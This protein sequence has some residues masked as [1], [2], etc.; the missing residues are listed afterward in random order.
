MLIPLSQQ[1]EAI[2]MDNIKAIKDYAK[3]LG[4]TNIS[5]TEFDSFVVPSDGY[6][7]MVNCLESE[8]QYRNQKA[9]ERRIKQARIPAYKTFGEFDTEFQ[10]GISKE[11][12]NT[13]SNLNWIDNIYNLILLGPPGTGK[14]H[15]ALAIGNRALEMG[16]KV[17]FCSMDTLIHILKT[18]EISRAS[19]TK[20]NYIKKCHL[21]IIDELGYLPIDKIETN[22][23]FQLISYL[24]EHTSVIITS[25]KG[26]DGWAD[27]LGDTVLA[28]ALLDR[29]TYKCQVIS[30]SGD[31]Y[32]LAHRQNIFKE[33]QK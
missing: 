5:E 2:S 16:Y 32:R 25:N 13:L 1:K 9:K 20:L 10:S 26:F 18:H 12:L 4:L 8:Y 3:K 22:M 33:L 24:Y 15:V 6:K 30:L 23:F 27:L 19:A 14:T 17:F 29:L 7:F 31:S 21:L 28:T 11:Q